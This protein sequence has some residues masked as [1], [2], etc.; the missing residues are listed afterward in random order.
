M[1]WVAYCTTC[2]EL[3]RAPNGAMMESVARLHRRDTGHMTIIGHE[4]SQS[5]EEMDVEE[6][7][8]RQARDRAEEFLGRVSQP[9]DVRTTQDRPLPQTYSDWV[10][11][12]E[13]MKKYY[14]Y[15]P[16]DVGMI[17]FQLQ[18]ISGEGSTETPE[19]VAIAKRWLTN[20]ATELG[21]T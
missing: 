7:R 1:D 17:N 13:D 16:A 21:I 4:P 18:T 9:L 3:D 12:A 15:N 20:K 10:D 14:A 6:L 5:Q 11:L 19:A 8:R 2:G